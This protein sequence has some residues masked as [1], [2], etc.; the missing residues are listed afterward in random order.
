MVVG[1]RE[2][3]NFE[4]GSL[5]PEEVES[6]FNGLPFD[7]TFVD[8]EDT[9]RFYSE[10]GGR[11]FPRSKAVIG[12]KVQRCH[13]RKS[14]HVVNQ[15]LEGFR[16]GGRG[17]AEFWIDLG[18]RKILIRYFPVRNEAGEYLGCVEIT[19]DITEIKRIEGEKRL[20]GG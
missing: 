2:A 13:P 5:T 12:M 9:V 14:V 18:G 7:I 4:T 3:L 8:A 11:I 20:L 16:A 15:I 19:Q 6:I 17:S 10:S 1:R